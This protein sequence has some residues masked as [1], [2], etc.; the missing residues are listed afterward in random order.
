[1]SQKGYRRQF[2][3]KLGFDPFPGTLN[4]KLSSKADC[5]TRK[6][7]ETYPAILIE[8]FGNEHRSFG[9]LRCYK[10]V[11]NG[12]VQGALMIIQRTH[13]DSSVVELIAPVKLREELNLKEGDKV[14]VEAFISGET[15]PH[16][17]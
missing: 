8:G 1:V 6:E 7:L 16:R 13:Y 3:E 2:I 11:I 15:P 5:Q 9:P 14:V 4:I 10:A 17:T 12:Q